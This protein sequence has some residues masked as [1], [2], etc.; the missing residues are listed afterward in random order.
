[1]RRQAPSRALGAGRRL[2][3]RIERRDE[4]V[5]I[6]VVNPMIRSVRDVLAPQENAPVGF[7]VPPLNPDHTAFGFDLDFMVRGAKRFEDVSQGAKHM[8]R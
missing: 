8:H 7:E 4:P 5:N 1:M 3:D 6:V 2:P